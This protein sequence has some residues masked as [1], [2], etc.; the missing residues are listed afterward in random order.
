MKSIKT[1]LPGVIIIEPDVYGDERGFFFESFRV[2]RY[3]EHGIDL[4]FVQDN[5]SRSTQGVL[6]GLHA[7]KDHLQG[8]LV[9]TVL[10]KVFDVAVD[11]RRDSPTFGQWEGV[12]LDD[13]NHRQFYVPPGFAHGFCALSDVAI[14]VYKCTDYYIQE[15]EIAIKWDDPDIAINWPVKEPIVSPKD[16]VAPFLKDIPLENL[17]AWKNIR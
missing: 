7:Q 6:R 10:G 8:K 3:K 2:N 4:P 14:F 9:Q 11:V 15:S 13:Q 17:S 16:A 12:M 5:V 1:K